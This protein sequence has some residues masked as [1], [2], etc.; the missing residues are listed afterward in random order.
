MSNKYWDKLS[1]FCS[2]KYKY[3]IITKHIFK[4]LTSCS[5]IKTK[6]LSKMCLSVAE[7]EAFRKLVQD[8]VCKNKHMAKSDIVNHFVSLGYA[9]CT[10]YKVLNK[11]TTESTTKEKKRTGRPSTWTLKKRYHLKGLTNNRFDVSQRKLAAKFDVCQKTICN[12]LRKMKISY[13]KREKS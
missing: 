4:I 1:Y 3:Y 2:D 10:M 8:F 12:Q 11:L 9:R 13:R 5:L 6:S 7:R